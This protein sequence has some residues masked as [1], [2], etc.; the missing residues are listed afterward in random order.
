MSSENRRDI[1][2]FRDLEV[3]QSAMRLVD[4][5][6][7][8][9]RTLPEAERFGL[10]AQMRRSAVSIPSN[11]AEGFGRDSKWDVLR[12]VEMARGSLFELST[13]AEV[14]LRQGSST[15]FAQIIEDG[16]DLGRLLTAFMTAIRKWP[17]RRRA[18]SRR[19]T[20]D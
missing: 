8:L 12:Y 14:C 15:A 6:Y 19:P 13:Q 3:W 10:V 11:I 5:T 9:T 2:T 7:D 1:E 20:N 4:R 17:E 18:S 16:E